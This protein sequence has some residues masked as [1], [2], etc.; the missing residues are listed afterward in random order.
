GYRTLC[1]AYRVLEK[2]FYDDWAKNYRKTID[3]ENDMTLIGVAAL[4]DILQE[5]NYAEDV[6]ETIQSLLNAK[7]RVWMITGDKAETAISCA[8]SSNFFPEEAEERLLKSVDEIKGLL[9]EFE[10]IA[11]PKK[12]SSI[13][14]VNM[15]V[16]FVSCY[17]CLKPEKTTNNWG[18]EFIL[19]VEGERLLFFH[20][21][22]NLERTSRVAYSA[23]LLFLAILHCF[24]RSIC[25]Y[26]IQMWFAFFSAFSC[27]TV[28]DQTSVIL[29]NLL[30]TVLPPIM[31]GIFEK[32]T[33]Q[34][35]VD[36]MEYNALQKKAFTITIW[37]NIKWGAEM[38]GVASIMFSSPSFWLACAL[39]PITTLFFDFMWKV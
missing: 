16:T 14:L 4:E 11:K 21:A 32:A 23:L 25:F 13:S 17:C 34:K 24:H 19:T 9:S 35:F 5:L 37:P 6:P 38:C 30:F 26:L 3:I 22:C 15:T 28:F 10:E 20:G 1:F 27:Q 2:N 18:K 29:F 36:P 12:Y 31:I 8:R 7:I 33:D 39:V